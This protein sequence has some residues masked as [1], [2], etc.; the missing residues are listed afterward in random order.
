[1]HVFGWTL[2]AS[3]ALFASTGANAAAGDTARIIDEGMNRSQVM[4]TAHELMDGIGPRL[5]ISSNMQRAQDW[6]IAKFGSYGLSAIHRE[7]FTF[8]RG[9]DIVNSSV[10]LVSPR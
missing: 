6:A 9:W 1:M 8:G 10:R 3:A 5:T 7:G 4:L 2:M